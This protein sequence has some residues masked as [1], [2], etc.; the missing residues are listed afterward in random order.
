MEFRSKDACYFVY[1]LTNDDHSLLDVGVTGNLSDRIYNVERQAM[2][3]PVISKVC[4]CL[5]YLESFSDVKQA[6]LREQRIKGYSK[7]KKKH[8]IHQF[9]PDWRKMNKEIYEKELLN[10]A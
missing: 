6:V 10:K 9:N 8:L 4:T 2:D 7:N 3:K 5:V 1:M